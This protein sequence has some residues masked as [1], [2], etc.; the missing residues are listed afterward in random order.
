MQRQI[1]FIGLFVCGMHANT[2]AQ[3][4]LHNGVW[5]CQGALFYQYS[6]SSAPATPGTTFDRYDKQH[7]VNVVPS[8]GY[9]LSDQWEISVIPLISFASSKFNYGV[10]FQPAGAPASEIVEGST[11]SKQIDA[12]VSVGF[13]FHIPLSEKM[14]SFIGT[15][16]GF[17]WQKVTYEFEFPNLFF[18]ETGIWSK[19]QFIY[20]TM[21]L[22]LKA[23]ISESW[24]FIP[25]VRM[26]YETVEQSNGS[27]LL[28]Y[29]HK[30]SVSFGVGFAVYMDK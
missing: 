3:D 10:S 14:T 17:H 24:A 2:S 30:F 8:I 26:A 25:Q 20:P 16:T 7:E 23:F 9:F 13:F 6:N 1:I 21:N 22:G 28:D 19:P 11:L 18:E 5:E 15:T 29:D 4:R 27:S 12:G